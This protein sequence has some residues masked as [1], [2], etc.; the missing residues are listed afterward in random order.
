VNYLSEA[1]FQLWFPV[2]CILGVVFWLQHLYP[3]TAEASLERWFSN[4]ESPGLSPISTNRVLLCWQKQLEMKVVC[5][6]L[7]AVDLH[8]HNPGLSGVNPQKQIVCLPSASLSTFAL[9]ASYIG[10][11]RCSFPDSQFPLKINL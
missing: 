6:A 3:T 10:V 9:Q 7:Q 11:A 8:R 2:S 5:P 1:G 4:L